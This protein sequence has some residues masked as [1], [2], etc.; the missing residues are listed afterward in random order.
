MNEINVTTE[1]Y[2]LENDKV[3]L[4]RKKQGF[5]AGKIIGPGG[6]V[7]KF[8][9]SIKSA[10]V[11]EV[12]EELG[13][14][15]STSDIVICGLVYTLIRGKI[16]KIW[17]SRVT[18]YTRIPVET[19]EAFPLWYSFKSVPYE[20]MW[21]ETFYWFSLLLAGDF[22]EGFFEYNDQEGIVDYILRGMSKEEWGKKYNLERGIV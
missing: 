13:I 18:K 3:L 15:V 5:G 7:E 2:V 9:N 17:V 1:L 11:R 12:E 10:S 16:Y 19:D 6:H 4:I 21:P 8:D 20:E 22:F 14:C